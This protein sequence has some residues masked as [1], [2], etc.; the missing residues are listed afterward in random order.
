MKFIKKVILAFILTANLLE[1]SMAA[2]SK[3]VIPQLAEHQGSSLGRELPVWIDDINENK[4]QKIF[5]DLGIDSNEKQIFVIAGRNKNL[6]VAKDYAET[7][8]LNAELPFALRLSIS[9]SANIILAVM[10]KNKEISKSTRAA[11]YEQI[12]HL[13]QNLKFE[14][15]QKEATYWIK[16]QVLNKK[17]NPKKAKPS[18]YKNEYIYFAVYSMN[19]NLYNQKIQDAM[20]NLKTFQF[21]LKSDSKSNSK[22]QNSK[23]EVLQEILQIDDF[24]KT[25]IENF[26]Q[27]IL[28]EFDKAIFPRNKIIENFYEK[29]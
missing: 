11:L 22:N 10:E 2:S 15:L 6:D 9:S 1:F 16:T 18:D 5:E 27:E 25:G 19:K 20:Q 12:V 17:I 29:K 24:E 4:N 28:S 23:T 8:D 21:T 26:K 7:L 14:D 13:A 3:I